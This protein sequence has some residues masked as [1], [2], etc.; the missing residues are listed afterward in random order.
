MESPPADAGAPAPTAHELKAALPAAT[1]GRA[2]NGVTISDDGTA[3]LTIDSG[4][5][6]RLWPAL[7]GTREPVAVPLVAPQDVVLARDGADFAIAAL[8]TAGGLVLLRVDAN[9]QLVGKASLPFDQP[10]KLVVAAGNGFLAIK[11]DQTVERVDYKG[12]HLGEVAPETGQRIA[13]LVARRGRAMAMLTSPEGVIARWLDT[14]AKSL[15]WGAAT[16]PLAIDAQQVALSPDFTKLAAIQK[17]GRR[18]IILDLATGTTTR[19]RGNRNDLVPLNWVSEDRIAFAHDEFELSRVEWFDPTGKLISAIGDDFELE[20]VSVLAM[21][22]ADNRVVSFM[23]H[24]L[25]LVEPRKLRYLGYQTHAASRL[26]AT[27]AGMVASMGGRSQILDD[28]LQI[29]RR[30]PAANARD[31]LPIDD[32]FALAIRGIPTKDGPFDDSIADPKPRKSGVEVVLFEGQTRQQVVKMKVS[33]MRLRYEPATRLLATNGGSAITFA[34]FDDTAKRFGE[35]VTLRVGAP[36]RDIFLL[37]PKTAANGAIALVV[38]GAKGDLVV[39]P[40]FEAE[41]MGALPHQAI[42]LPGELEA[43]DRAGHTYVR[44]DAKTVTIFNGATE[45]GKLTDLDKMKV[46]P[47]PDGKRVA[48]FGRGRV[49]LANLDGTEVWSIGFPAIKDLQWTDNDLV[50]LANGIAKLDPATGQ[51][52]AARCGWKF[53]LRTQA[54]FMDLA[55]STICD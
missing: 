18:A 14:S 42:A 31:L 2:I 32:T 6:V 30:A 16:A 1:H 37:D 40:I 34:R 54:S 22:A 21:D 7:D 11:A 13:T 28:S 15:A 38:H 53:G 12:T 36:I 9:G 41:L 45:L 4:N 8:D 17:K 47:A 3:A 44:T 26:R 48:I 10:Y 5:H 46:R 23:G 19:L 29:E 55:G 39:R 20:F 43:V 49:I 51:T 27:P 24:Q 50:A 25:V 52:I 33:E 35:P